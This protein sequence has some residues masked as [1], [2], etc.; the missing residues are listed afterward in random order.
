MHA[1][2]FQLC[3]T[4]VCDPLD[5]SPPGSSVHGILQG[6]GCHALHQGIFPTQRWNP[7][8][9]TSP[10]LADGFFTT[11]VTW[12]G[13]PYELFISGILHLLFLDCDWPQVTETAESETVD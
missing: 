9:L 10:A 1:K 6:V 11:S 3:P 7:H 8:L 13:K 12:E 2:L 5:H 4:T